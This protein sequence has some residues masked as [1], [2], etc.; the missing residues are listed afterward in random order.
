MHSVRFA[1]RVRAYLRQTNTAELACLD[2]FRNVADSVL[3]LCLWI[4]PSALEQIKTLLAIQHLQTLVDAALDVLLA[5]VWSHFT[6]CQ[7]ALDGQND[8]LRI[9][10]VFGKVS[11]EKVEGVVFLVAVE[12]AAIPESCAAG[13]CC[14]HRIE[15][16]R[17]WRWALAPCEAWPL[18]V[19]R[20]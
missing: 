14:A 18:S 19:R 7:T 9:P 1:D 17:L 5:A 20:K 2:V 6:W 4:N 8:L 16:L 13:K 3:N 10:G 15:A 12:L 11:V